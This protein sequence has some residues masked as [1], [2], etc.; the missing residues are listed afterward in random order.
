MLHAAFFVSDE[1]HVRTV[2]LPDGSKH[3][4]HFRQ[5]PASDFRRYQAAMQSDVE[6]TRANGVA[7]IIAASVC[8]PDGKPAMT[9]KDALR[10]KVQAERAL[11][12][13]VMSV[14]DMADDPAAA[15]EQGNALPAE[16]PSGSG[17]S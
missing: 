11:A 10:L 1:L 7:G 9:L 2:E 8:T 17:T 16:G 14:N 5:L 4:L 13:A 12:A 6:Q 15:G 3:E